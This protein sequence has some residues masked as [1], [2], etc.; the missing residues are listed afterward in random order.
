MRI[1]VFDSVFF[2]SFFF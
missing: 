2:F 1:H